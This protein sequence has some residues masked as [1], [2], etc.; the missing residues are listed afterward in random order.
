MAP[1]AAWTIIAAEDE[2][3][4][5]VGRE[6]LDRGDPVTGPPDMT[7]SMN[8]GKTKFGTIRT[9][10]RSVRDD[11]APREL[12]ELVARGTAFTGRRPGWARQARRRR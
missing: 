7:A 8:S 3:H 11:R 12:S 10:W 1:A 5:G 9:G 6:S 2:C 4:V